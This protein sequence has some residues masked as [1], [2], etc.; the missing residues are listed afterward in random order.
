MSRE[1]SHTWDETTIPTKL[2][3]YVYSHINEDACLRLKV[4]LGSRINLVVLNIVDLSE[5]YHAMK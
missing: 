3:Q 4:G 2:A 5:T 1:G